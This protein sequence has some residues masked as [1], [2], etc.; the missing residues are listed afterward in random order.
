MIRLS[1]ADHAH[2]IHTPELRFV[3]YQSFIATLSLFQSTCVFLSNSTAYCPPQLSWPPQ[4]LKA[5]SSRESPKFSTEPRCSCN[6]HRH[7]HTLFSS[8]HTNLQHPFKARHKQSVCAVE[9][10]QIRGASNPKPN[11]KS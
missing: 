7:H 4:G 5:L 10:I 2:S 9:A 3:Q 1:P 8:M 6:N 11:C